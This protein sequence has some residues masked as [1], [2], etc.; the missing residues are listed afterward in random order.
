MKNLK[1]VLSLVLALAMALSLMTVAFAKD[2]HDYTDFDEVTYKEAVDVMSAI[3]V[4]DGMNSTTFDPNGTLT[5]EQAAK[6]ITYMLLGPDAA[7]KLGPQSTGFTDVPASRWSSPYIGYCASRGIVNGTS[8]TTFDPT[9]KLTGYAF[10]KMLLTSLG[11]GVND[12]Y[13][14]KAWTLAVAR[15]GMQI[16]LYDEVQVSNAVITRNE[17]A[18]LAFDALNTNQVVWSELFNTYTAYSLDLGNQ[19]LL[20]TLADKVFDLTPT[21]KDDGYHYTTRAWRQGNKVVTDYYNIDEIIA[22]VTDADTTVGALLK[23]YEWQTKDSDGHALKIPM[24]VNGTQRDADAL[25]TLKGLNPGAKL[26]K[27][28]Y[29]VNLVDSDDNGEVDK[30]VVVVEYLAKVTRVNAATSSEDRS[31]NLDIYDTTG[32]VTKTKVETEDF[33]KDQYILIVPNSDNTAGFQEPLEMKAAQVVTGSVSAFYKDSVVDGSKNTDGSVTVDGTKYKYN[34]IFAYTADRALGDDLAT[35]GYTL[36]SKATYNFYLDSLGYVIGVEVADDSISDYAY[37]IDKGEDAFQQHNIAKV[38]L[39]N[40]TVATYTISDDSDAAALDTTTVN[41]DTSSAKAGT[42]WAYSINSANEIVLTE[43]TGKYDQVASTG[44]G[45]TIKSFTKGTTVIKLSAS[46]FAYATDETVF[47][48][49]NG[50]KVV[51]T[52]TGKDN[53][54]SISNK[55]ASVAVKADS[56]GINYAQFV[57][58]TD[59]PEA[60]TGDNFVYA[61]SSSYKGFSTD[62]NGDKIYYFE[63][64]KG[65]EKVVIATDK[66]ALIAGDVYNYGVKE[67][68]FGGDSAND[69]LPGV[70]DLTAMPV[71]GY[72][73]GVDVGVVNAGVIT[74]NTNT[75]SYVITPDTVIAD[76]DLTDSTD[77]VVFEATVDDDDI[78]TVVYD[79]VGGLNV[80]KAIFITETG[81]N[82]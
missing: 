25:A 29:Q 27:N 5:R 18:Q 67:D 24:Y 55:V 39:S 2:A 1:K 53:A 32:K 15:D 36:G 63:V 81:T 8:A 42:I 9:G 76:V 43:L 12:E 34:S 21:F 78:I 13:V 47:V 26:L 30:V 51:G 73:K 80:A 54:P 10:A 35:N 33:A 56:K 58:V 79:V 11:Y 20:G 45:N 71:S 41:S 64:I 23:D 65:G 66:T 82:G 48:Y 22:T 61:L 72:T 7:E 37:I 19:Q 77:S 50:G 44:D 17:A 57:V 68:A 60:L 75:T 70:Y 14:G 49:Y 74:D 46:D 38:L 52:Y 69:V 3:G 31:V 6:I 4:I 40:G 59:A 16:G 28:G 62:N